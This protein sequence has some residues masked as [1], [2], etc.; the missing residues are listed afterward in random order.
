M[1][2]YASAFG[3]HEL[4]LVYPWYPGLVGSKSAEIRLPPVQGKSPVLR[5]ICIDVHADELPL[6][7]GRWFPGL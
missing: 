7:I 3:C 2:A 4:Q 6:R 5:V 1:Q